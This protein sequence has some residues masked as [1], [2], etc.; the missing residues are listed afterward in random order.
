MATKRAFFLHHM[1]QTNL[2]PSLLEIER[3]EGIYLYDVTGN[4]Y[5]DLNSGIGP[6]AFGHGHPAII[7]AIKKQTN[8]YAHTMVYGEFVQSPQVDLAKCLIDHLPEQLDTVYFLNSGTEA[9]EAAMKL[10]RKYTSRYEIISA[11]RAYHGS[12]IGAESLRSDLEFTMHYQPMVP[13]IKHITFNNPDDLS[14]ITT[15]TAAVIMETIQAEGGVLLPTNDYLK[16]L[17]TRCDQTGTLLVLDEIQV[18]MGR[19]GTF[20]AFEQYG[21]VPDVLLMAKALGGGLPL[22]A[23]IAPQAIMKTLWN[24]PTHGHLTTFGGNPVCCAA[25]LAGLKLL[26]EDRLLDIISEKANIIRKRLVHPLI[27]EVRQ[28]GLMVGID[29]GD[30]DI[31]MRIIQA[32]FDKRI[33]VDYLLF[34]DT[35]FRIAPPLIIT[36]KELHH[37]LD[38]I[39]DTMDEIKMVL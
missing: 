30:K 17:R 24:D 19:T 35:T 14:K 38:I 32:L 18:A 6:C 26:F 7:D 16:K 37:A 27:V 21:I 20:C 5:V 13:G 39:L 12:T 33:L 1:G 11:R 25:G 8:L 28:A 36:E 3:A 4:R 31:N 29:V 23:F 22:A 15:Q 34:N 9:V 2:A 10:A